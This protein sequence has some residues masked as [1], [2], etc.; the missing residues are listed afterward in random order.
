MGFQEPQRL[1]ERPRERGEDVSGVGIPGFARCVDRRTS[2]I[3]KIAVAF[4]QCGG[5]VFHADEIGRIGFE[6]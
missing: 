2:R 5:M 3:G 6:F 1:I 4:C